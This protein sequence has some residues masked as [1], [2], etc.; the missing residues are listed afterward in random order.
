MD[1]IY[2]IEED[3]IIWREKFWLIICEYFGVKAIGD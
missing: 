1:F 2:S 3:F